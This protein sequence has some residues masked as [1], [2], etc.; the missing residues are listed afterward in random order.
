MEK[1]NDE[2]AVLP[3]ELDLL[4]EMLCRERN[5][6]AGSRTADQSYMR[7]MTGSL[8]DDDSMAL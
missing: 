7:A 8:L 5:M 2:M 4:A 3:A 6:L 1:G